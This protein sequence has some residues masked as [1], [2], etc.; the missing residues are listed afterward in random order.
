[1]IDLLNKRRFIRPLIDLGHNPLLC[2][3]LFTVLLN[4][5]FE[6]I[7]PL[8]PVLTGS[9]QE[10]IIRSVLSTVLVVFLV[11]FATRRRIFWQT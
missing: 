10:A 9:P 8:R 2:Y 4:S 11:R 1:M 3:L 5:F 6:L 7:P